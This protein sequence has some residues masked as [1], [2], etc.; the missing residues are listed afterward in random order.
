MKRRLKAAVVGRIATISILGFLVAC[1]FEDD[2][3]PVDW[4]MGDERRFGEVSSSPVNPEEATEADITRVLDRLFEPYHPPDDRP[5]RG[6]IYERADRLLKG[7]YAYYGYDLDDLAIRRQ[8]NPLTEQMFLEY[9]DSQHVT[10][11]KDPAT[12]EDFLVFAWLATGTIGTRGGVNMDV[13]D[14]V[15][16]IDLMAPMNYE[17]NYL[18]AIFRWHGKA[19]FDSRQRLRREMKK[20]YGGNPADVYEYL[21][22]VDSFGVD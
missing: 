15:G 13:L 4:Q 9:L 3:V 19:V 14:R 8:D 1:E 7:A 11:I 18:D 21:E 12:G 2:L 10:A 17:R 20:Q 6:S 22:T 5:Y 16:G